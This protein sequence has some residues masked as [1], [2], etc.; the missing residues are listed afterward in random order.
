[1]INLSWTWKENY[2]DIRVDTYKQGLRLPTQGES[3]II[4]L[5]GTDLGLEARALKQRRRTSHGAELTCHVG[6]HLKPC[7]E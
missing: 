7:E 2:A 1:M 5:Q 3:D 4:S 6:L